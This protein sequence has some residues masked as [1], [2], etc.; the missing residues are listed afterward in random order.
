MRH[1]LLVGLLIACRAESPPLNPYKGKSASGG[2]PTVEFAPISAPSAV[3]TK[4]DGTEIDLASLW[5]KQKVVVVFYRG[6]WCP[7]CQKQLGDLQKNQMQ[8]AK[9]DAIIVGITSDSVEDVNKTR[10]K[11][12]LNYELYSDPGL[13]V[14]S[15]WGVEDVGNGIARPAT[16]V[17]ER[18]GTVTYRKIGKSP[19]DHP[20]VDELIAALEQN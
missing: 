2:E 19:A 15:L 4:R 5:E 16:F 14:I 3:V 12:A 11:L 1:F 6:G 10:D 18:G 9:A 17:V 8:F 20:S 7:H 13:K